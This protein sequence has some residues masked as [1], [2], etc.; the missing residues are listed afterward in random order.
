MA[1]ITSGKKISALDETQDT[2]DA[3]VVVAKNGKNYK[4]AVSN[5]KSQV[6]TTK[7]DQK[8]AQLEAKTVATDTKVSN[9][10]SKVNAMQTDVDDNSVEIE[11]ARNGEP[12]LGDRLDKV[13]ATAKKNADWSVTD[14]AD[15]AYI[16]NKPDIP[17]KT[18]Q[19]TNDS[20]FADKTFVQEEIAKASTGGGVDLSTYA[21][22]AELDQT[23]AELQASITAHETQT[24]ADLALK[25]NTTDVTNAL[26]LKAD[27]AYTDTELAKKVDKE[28]GKGLSTNDFTTALKT[29]LESVEDGAEVNV[30]SDWDVADTTADAFIKNKPNLDLYQKKEDQTLQTTSKTITGAIEELRSEIVAAR[31]KGATGGAGTT[32]GSLDARLDEMDTRIDLASGGTG[33]TIDL[34][35][36]MQKTEL[37]TEIEKLNKYAL[38]EDIGTKTSLSTTSKDT[39]VNA[40]N[41]VDLHVG[42]PTS[43]TTTAKT[44]AVAAINEL[45]GEIGALTTLK[46]TEKTTVVG[47]IN[48]LFDDKLAKTDVVDNLTSTDTDKPLS[49]N[50][51]KVLKDDMGDKANLTTTEKGNLVGAINEL[52]AEIGVLTNLTT[53]EQGTIVG[54]I[55]EHEE[56]IGVI[57]DLDVDNPVGGAKYDNLVEAVNQV[58]TDLGDITALEVN[59]P[60]L[61]DVYDNTVEAINELHKELGDT[62][63]LEVK[64]KNDALIDNH[65]DAINRLNELV[66]IIKTQQQYDDL[67]VKETDR[68]YITKDKFNMYINDTLLNERSVII[69]SMSIEPMVAEIGST[70][71]DVHV[72][73][74]C[75]GIPQS[76][77]INSTDV[78]LASNTLIYGDELVE[79]DLTGA[80]LVGLTGVGE[81]YLAENPLN[82]IIYEAKT[83]S[84]RTVS[85]MLEVKF[86]N[87]IYHGVAEL[88]ATY[89]SDFIKNLEGSL[90][91]GKVLSPSKKGIQFLDTDKNL[92]VTKDGVE[93]GLIDNK[94]R[95]IVVDCSINKYIYYCVPSKYLD[96]Q[97][98]P[99][100]FI[101]GLMGGMQSEGK[102][103][104]TNASG[105]TEDYDIYRS[106]NHSL[107]VCFL[108]IK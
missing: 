9:V 37:P 34:S 62:D 63:L 93:Y 41:E 90:A 70:V 108:E 7:I 31:Q 77:K 66:P 1:E 60:T 38:K 67:A 76:Q 48:E 24:T 30:Q 80:N 57:A 36:Y 83:N 71:A 58:H 10:E 65:T 25:A 16:R 105:Y 6:D 81:D 61:T 29:K 39:L 12:T 53:D 47:A 98:E 26:A 32:Y 89:D 20:D 104:F 51:G 45:D 100:F 72:S 2:T 50:Q 68:L 49:A 96:A 28:T 82:K 11:L 54:A 85:E 84:G 102:I 91:G 64:D 94:G 21:K 3:Y 13:E 107:G 92:V 43:L 44:S 59:K 18:S 86:M 101:N 99:Y 14:Q 27:K 42:K 22:K 74:V 23:K 40:I 75:Q 56:Q 97:G 103:S 35:S 73:V 5:L 19:L 4:V 52:D 95:D 106:V 46:T 69:K 88:P 17:T 78:P 8:L 87:G 55:N 15:V 79:F 33:A